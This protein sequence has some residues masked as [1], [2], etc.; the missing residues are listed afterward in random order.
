[1][2]FLLCN[3]QTQYVLIY[4]MLKEYVEQFSEYGNFQ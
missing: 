2:R 4:Q 1:M 3:L